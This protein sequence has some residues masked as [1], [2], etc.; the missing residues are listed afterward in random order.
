[1]RPNIDMINEAM[2]G[3]LQQILDPSDHGML[4]IP[5][6][7]NPGKP[8]SEL[9]V[10]STGGAIILMPMAA[11]GTLFRWNE[12]VTMTNL[13]PGQEGRRRKKV[14]R[15]HLMLAGLT[16]FLFTGG[17]IPSGLTKDDV[18]QFLMM[19]DAWSVTSD[20]LS[21]NKQIWEYAI[22]QQAMMVLHE[23]GHIK[24]INR[25]LEYDRTDPVLPAWDQAKDE[26]A[27]DAH[28]TEWIRRLAD[29]LLGYLD[30]GRRFASDAVWY[31][32]TLLDVVNRLSGMLTDPWQ[33]SV[34]FIY[35]LNDLGALEAYNNFGSAFQCIVDR[36]GGR[37]RGDFVV[38]CERVIGDYARDLLIDRERAMQE[39][40]HLPPV[41]DFFGGAR[42]SLGLL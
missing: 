25:G 20:G 19:L 37:E 2:N 15:R 41:P 17:A 40:L 29:S 31:Y 18:S 5:R 35:L 33:L 32:F 23:F 39:E 13:Y 12:Y 3:L 27:A 21:H 8:S 38:H 4:D 6:V 1:M 34:R 10:S 28:S 7:L 30:D 16:S 26:M 22:F 11:F 14:A 24:L 36:V 42:T 9:M